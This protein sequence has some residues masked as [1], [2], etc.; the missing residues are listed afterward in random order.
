M[1]RILLAAIAATAA[2]A[3]LGAAPA[4]AHKRFPLIIKARNLPSLQGAAYEA[5]VVKGDR[6]ISAGKFN[7]DGRRVVVLRSPIRPRR[8]DRIVVTIEPARDA[9]PGPTDVVILAGDVRWHRA[10][11]SFPV[12]LRELAGVFLLATP[13]SASMEDET[14]GVWFIDPAKGP[15]P[16]LT[17]PALPSGWKFE[18]W[19]VTQGTALTTGRFSTAAGADESAPFS[20]PLPG[21]PFPGEDF[22]ANLPSSVRPPVNL[23]DGASRVVLT[24][25]PDIDGSDPTGPA[26]FPISPLA[27]DIPA[28]AAP[29]T[30]LPLARDLSTVPFG[31]A[32]F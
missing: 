24:V 16:G 25:E 26:P 31:R 27:G 32:L 11:L 29:M 6:K 2:L 14:A 1:R 21:P 15:G 20:G 17:L 9:D 30:A 7:A 8:A 4:V 28:G 23:A 10:E 3:V 12:N 5:W 22:L 18:G 13:T 19:G